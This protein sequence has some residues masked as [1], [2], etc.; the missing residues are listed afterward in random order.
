MN[1]VIKM[2]VSF[3]AKYNTLQKFNSHKFLKITAIEWGTG[4][5]ARKD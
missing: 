3:K 1:V 5:T 4:E 2:F